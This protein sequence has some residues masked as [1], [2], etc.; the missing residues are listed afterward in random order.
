MERK[1]IQYPPYEDVLAHKGN[2]TIFGN[3]FCK[4]C[5]SQYGIRHRVCIGVILD[6]ADNPLPATFDST[7]DGYEQAKDLC[8]AWINEQLKEIEQ[9][10]YNVQS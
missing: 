9:E 4:I 10:F 8:N 7:P 5:I 6:G 3:R 2:R 1:E